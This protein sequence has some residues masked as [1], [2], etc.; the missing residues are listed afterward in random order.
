MAVPGCTAPLPPVRTD[1]L[2]LGAACLAAQP[3][4]ITK[5]TRCIWPRLCAPSRRHADATRR[6]VGALACSRWVWP[7][8]HEWG[9]PC[10]WL[11]LSVSHGCTQMVARRALAVGAACIP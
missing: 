1:A 10:M 8:S 6:P 2:L 9:M 5:R 3:A 11:S 7:A 4:D